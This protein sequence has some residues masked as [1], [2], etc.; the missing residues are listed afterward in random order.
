MKEDTYRGK[1]H[2]FKNP[3]CQRKIHN[4]DDKQEEDKQVEATLSPAVNS[5]FVDILILRPL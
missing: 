5:D 3:N 4:E 2:H 1:P